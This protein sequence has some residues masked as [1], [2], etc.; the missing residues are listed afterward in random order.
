MSDLKVTIITSIF[1]NKELIQDAIHSV[2]EQTYNNIEHLIIDGNS[3]D[4]SK[5][6]IKKNMNNKIRFHSENDNG[7]YEALNKGINLS[8]GD[9]IGILHSDDIFTDSNVI[10]E[11]VN[12]FKK[13]NYDMLYGDI[14]YI[15]KSKNKKIL[16][17]WKANNFLIKNIK[18]GWMPP[19]TSTFIKKS[20]LNKVGLYNT[21]FQI[22][23]DYDLLTRILTNYKIS[24]GY[25]QKVLVLM[26]V[27]GKS[28]KNLRNI[29]QK[30]VEDYS[31]I[32]RN[33]I[34]GFYTLIFK[35][36]TKIKQLF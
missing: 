15:S 12:E 4:G 17:K 25:L 33:K 28:N 16:R 13:Y 5:D 31:I 1:N 18:Y 2:N 27:G 21:Q 35:N 26:R 11:V 10:M 29:Y 7:I 6:T 32:K 14:N 24:I 30:M 36:L 9:I 23:A 19:H 34:G 22:S 8:S 20:L 3:T